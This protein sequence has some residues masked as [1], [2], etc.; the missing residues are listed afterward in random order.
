MRQLPLLYKPHTDQINFHVSKKLDFLNTLIKKNFENEIV[1]C[2]NVLHF[3]VQ[4]QLVRSS[5]TF[6]FNVDE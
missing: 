4:Q 1:F 5:Y 6:C 2:V 3:R